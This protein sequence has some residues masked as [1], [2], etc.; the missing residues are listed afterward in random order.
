M[1]PPCLAS[2]IDRLL[3]DD[4]LR[5]T[6][7]QRAREAFEAQFTARQMAERVVDVLMDAVHT[8]AARD[9]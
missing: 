4:A 1:T 6:I 9:P 5:A 7:G 8:A 3:K 2:A